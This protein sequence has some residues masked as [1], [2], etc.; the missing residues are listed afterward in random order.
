MNRDSE[1]KITIECVREFRRV[2]NNEH[3]RRALLIAIHLSDAAKL[4]VRT[5]LHSIMNI[6][7][8]K[9]CS[10]DICR[11]ALDIH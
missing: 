10:V 1:V 6:T 5:T 11:H 4:N 8:G 3:F 9:Y 7:T 2:N